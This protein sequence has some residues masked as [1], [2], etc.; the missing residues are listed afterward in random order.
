[1]D[2]GTIVTVG[3]AVLGQV[4]HIVKKR[5]EESN[6]SEIDVFKA[7]IVNKPFNTAGAVVASIV[8][9]LGLGE[10]L[11]ETVSL[12]MAFANAF[13]AGVAANSTVNRPGK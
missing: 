12:F 8:V 4:A 5:T 9:A 11:A 7:W 2:I 10:N 6:G 1:M 13:V 3:G